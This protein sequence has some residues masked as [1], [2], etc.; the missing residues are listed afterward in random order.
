MDRA[1]TTARRDEKRFSLCVSYW[2]L[3]GDMYIDVFCF[4]SLGMYHRIFVNLCD[5]MTYILQGCL[6]RAGTIAGIPQNM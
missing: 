2:R 4:V 1:K 3:Y 5:L 6:S